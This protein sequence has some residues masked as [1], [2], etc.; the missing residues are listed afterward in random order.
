MKSA[1]PLW[2]AIRISWPLLGGAW[3]VWLGFGGYLALAP[4]AD[5]FGSVLALGYFAV[6][7]LVGLVTGAASGALIGGLVDAVMRRSGVGLAGAVITATLVNALAIWQLA[8]LVQ[9]RY[10]GLRAHGPAKLHMGGDP[11]A[12][13][14]AVVAPMSST[15]G[16]S[17]RT[18][19]SGP[20]PTQPK[21]RGL[22]DSECR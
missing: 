2:R 12:R 7:A 11:G 10:P 22:W 1:D 17:S 15:T 18:A 4:N 21:E 3:G 16:S 5:S 20:P 13:A 8:D 9:T 19:C 14:P 6:F